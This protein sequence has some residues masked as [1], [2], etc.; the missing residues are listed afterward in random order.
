MKKI[1]IVLFVVTTALAAC[2][3]KKDAATPAT[4]PAAGSD[5]G[6]AMAP[7][8]GSGDAP[9]GGGSAAM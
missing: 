2:G 1:A 7:A 3:K 5:M 9:A 8:G 4:A 6:S